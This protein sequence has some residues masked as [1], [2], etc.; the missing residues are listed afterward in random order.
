MASPK[1]LIILTSHETLGSTGRRTGFW[2][3]ELAVPY[4]VFKAAGAQLTLSS[5]KGGRAPLDPRSEDPSA[6]AKAFMADAEAV[7]K[8]KNTRPVAATLKERFDA[9]FV[10]G[11]HGA[12]W[13]LS[14]DA[15]VVARIERS[16]SD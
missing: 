14:N 16:W 12:M 6:D 11:G 10:A 9:I 1:I 13:D 8:L 2:L 3:E 7:A 5:P 4:N 15:A